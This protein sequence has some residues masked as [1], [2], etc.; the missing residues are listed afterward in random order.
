MPIYT[1]QCHACHAD[2][3]LSR[4]VDDRETPILCPRCG[5]DAYYKPT[6]SGTIIF[7]SKQWRGRSS[8]CWEADDERTATQKQLVAAANDTD[9]SKLQPAVRHKLLETVKKQEGI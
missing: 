2:I 6:F 4:P 1:Y 3:D 8:V 5:S 7:S 9:K